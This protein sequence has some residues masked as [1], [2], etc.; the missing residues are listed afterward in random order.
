M[1]R[2]STLEDFV[3]P[4][5]RYGEERTLAGAYRYQFLFGRRPNRQI[6]TY[7]LFKFFQHKSL[8][9]PPELMLTSFSLS[10]FVKSAKAVGLHISKADQR[11]L[12][13]TP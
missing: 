10:H 3:E 5:R 8:I 12:K 7:T 1:S 9:D 13:E 6:E 11:K 4:I 2:L